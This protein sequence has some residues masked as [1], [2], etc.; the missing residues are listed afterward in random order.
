MKAIRS[1]GDSSLT[2]ALGRTAS[3]GAAKLL[4]TKCKVPFEILDL[5]IGLQATDV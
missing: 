3:L 5:P 4:D 1:A 2:I